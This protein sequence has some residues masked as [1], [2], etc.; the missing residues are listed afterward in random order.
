MKKPNKGGVKSQI[1]RVTVCEADTNETPMQ[2]VK[3]GGTASYR[4]PSL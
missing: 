3:P 1:A 4:Q 2:Q